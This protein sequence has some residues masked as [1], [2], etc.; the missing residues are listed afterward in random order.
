MGMV[1][2]DGQGGTILP[3]TADS[4]PLRSFRMGLFRSGGTLNPAYPRVVPSAYAAEILAKEK[5]RLV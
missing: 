3:D 2:R 5:N 4:D 1:T